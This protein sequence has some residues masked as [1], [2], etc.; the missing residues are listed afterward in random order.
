MIRQHLPH[1]RNLEEITTEVD[2][3]PHKSLDGHPPMSRVNEAPS[4]YNEGSKERHSTRQPK[5]QWH[6]GYEGYSR[7]NLSRRFSIEPS[8]TRRR[9]RKSSISTMSNTTFS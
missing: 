5:T 8:P 7:V 9:T 3:R 2:E 4:H 1:C 6:D